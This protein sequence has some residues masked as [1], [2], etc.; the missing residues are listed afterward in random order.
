MSEDLT[1]LREVYKKFSA[2]TSDEELIEK[3]DSLD[4]S[5]PKGLEELLHRLPA[6]YARVAHL[7]NQTE[8]EY[9]LYVE[10]LSLYHSQVWDMA[11]TEIFEANIAKGMTANNA[12]PTGKSIETLI[13]KFKQQQIKKEIDVDEVKKLLILDKKMKQKKSDL[14]MLKTLKKSWE[15]KAD[16]LTSVVLLIKELLRKDMYVVTDKEGFEGR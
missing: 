1:K 13:S 8:E 14:G 7:V 12:K 5:D 11:E 3:L 10:K 6:Y 4:T 15:M 2:K 16:M 9:N